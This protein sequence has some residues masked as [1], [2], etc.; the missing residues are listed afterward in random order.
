[1]T[2]GERTWVDGHE[3]RGPAQSKG[4]QVRKDMRN[5]SNRT[6]VGVDA[7][8]WLHKLLAPGTVG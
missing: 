4:P 8:W 6:R 1:M 5:L 3:R 2:Q 7:V